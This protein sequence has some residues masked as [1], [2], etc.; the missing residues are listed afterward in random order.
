MPFGV[1]SFGVLP[2]GV[3]SFGVIQRPYL[4]QALP[5]P[6]EVALADFHACSVGRPGA[7]L[8]HFL[9]TSTTREFRF[10]WIFDVVKLFTVAQTF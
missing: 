9:L 5:C 4:F 10:K 8:A 2:F 1:L 3:L 6:V 7:D